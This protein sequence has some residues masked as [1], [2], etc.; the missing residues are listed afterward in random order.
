MAKIKSALELALEKTAGIKTDPEALK[1]SERKDKARALA[2]KLLDRREVDLEAE[3]KP[4]SGKEKKEIKET[5]L[6]TLL[7]NL[8]LPA[9]P[10]DLTKTETLRDALKG[11][12][13]KPQMVDEIFSQ[14]QQVFEKFLEDKKQIKEALAQRYEP[15]LRQ[16]EQ[17]LAQQTG[18][19]VRLTPEQDPD[20]IKYFNHQVQQL[21]EQ[22]K[23]VLEQASGEFQRF[24]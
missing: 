23:G 14:L 19:Q 24:L 12:L 21:E 20:F 6:E 11:F 13:K 4:Y 9:Y 5:I 18:R 15:T 7:Q 22:Y 10:E 3:I 16:K 2:G 1:R 8:V 17:K